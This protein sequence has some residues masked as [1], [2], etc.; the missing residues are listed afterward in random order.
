MTPLADMEPKPWSGQ[1]LASDPQLGLILQQQDALARAMD[2]LVA[3]SARHYADG[4]K[5]ALH[6]LAETE[7]ETLRRFIMASWGH[8]ADGASKAAGRKIFTMI[9]A[10]MLA[11]ALWLVARKW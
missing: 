5:L 7:P 8:M 9:G 4:L 6:E 3:D 2:A 1:H 11:A 10:S